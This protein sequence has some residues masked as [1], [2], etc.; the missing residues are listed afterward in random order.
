MCWS[1]VKKLLT[2][3]VNLC[4]I[5][6]DNRSKC[7]LM[8]CLS[9]GCR[10]RTRPTTCLSLLKAMKTISSVHCRSAS[11]MLTVVAVVIVIVVAVV[12]VFYYWILSVNMDRI[13]WC[14]TLIGSVSL[15]FTVFSHRHRDVA[16]VISRWWTTL[17]PTHTRCLRRILS[18]TRSTRRRSSVHCV[19]ASQTPKQHLASRTL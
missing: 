19:I 18:S 12:M 7:V 11:L 5:L 14:V 10:H 17:S 3:C 1:A 4:I 16:V 8:M 15:F 13:L 6:R 9:G 2:H